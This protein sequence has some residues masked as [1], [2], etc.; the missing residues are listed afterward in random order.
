MGKRRTGRAFQSDSLRR[1]RLRWE[2][3]RRNEQHER[4]YK[5]F[6]ADPIRYRREKVYF[7][8]L[9]EG[10]T[11]EEWRQRVEGHWHW[12]ESKLAEFRRKWQIDHPHDPSDP[13]GWKAVESFGKREAVTI[14]LPPPDIDPSLGR[15]GPSRYL[16][17]RLDLIQPIERLLALVK[18]SILI[19]RSDLDPIRY[20]Y[21]ET[22][23]R[24]VHSLTDLEEALEVYDLVMK[25]PPEKRKWADIAREFKP[26]LGRVRFNP[27]KGGIQ[28]SNLRAAWEL[29][30]SRFKTANEYIQGRFREI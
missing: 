29:V 6:E 17:L 12:T 13:E 19:G 2:F 11:L 4:D 21:L 23:R 24:K 28:Q 25:H 8:P 20:A 14:I 22:K 27:A 9:Q 1:N 7:P 5:E 10:E 18:E 3:L 15:A 16:Y 26:E 30:Q